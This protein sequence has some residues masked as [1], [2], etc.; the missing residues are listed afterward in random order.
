MAECTML[1][2]HEQFKDNEVILPRICVTVRRA[3]FGFGKESCKMC[4]EKFQAETRNHQVS[5]HTVVNIF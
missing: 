5:D 2:G 3:S 4:L 1:N